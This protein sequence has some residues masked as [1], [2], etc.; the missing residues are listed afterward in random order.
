MKQ[1]TNVLFEHCQTIQ[2][3][4][5]NLLSVKADLEGKIIVINNCICCLEKNNDQSNLV[6]DAHRLSEFEWKQVIDTHDKLRVE[7][8][9]CRLVLDQ[10]TLKN[11][12]LRA[13]IMEAEIG[14]EVL[15][16]KFEVEFRDQRVS[17]L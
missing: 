11:R 1:E 16:K 17:E 12:N 2:S 10:R 5:S 9:T 8:Q 7:E 13:K 15:R 14:L 4:L 6:L 3:E